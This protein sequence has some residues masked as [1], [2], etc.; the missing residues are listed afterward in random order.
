MG[1]PT[2]AAIT[3]YNSHRG[4][5]DNGACREFWIKIP[6]LSA[7][8]DA[9]AA[10]PMY[11]LLNPFAQDM[12]VL[13]A[14]AVITTIDAQDGDIDVGLGDSAAGANDGAEII[15]SLV[16][17]A[18]GVFECTNIQALAGASKAIWKKSGTATDSYLCIAQNADADVS[19]LRWNLLLKLIPYED[20]IGNEGDQAALV[21]A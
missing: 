15:D 18:T 11:Y 5:F 16:N 2:I 8:S 20:L 9:D 7:A 13:N 21:V 1:D 19:A 17:T 10:S 3:T 6:G 14:L 4:T 12:V